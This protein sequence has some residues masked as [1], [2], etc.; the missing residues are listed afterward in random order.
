MEVRSVTEYGW[1]RDLRMV[2]EAKTY[3]YAK[4]NDVTVV[5]Y[6]FYQVY[7]KQGQIQ[8]ALKGNSVDLMV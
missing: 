3:D 6:Q 2:R 7:T 4:G 5:Q 8:E 1:H